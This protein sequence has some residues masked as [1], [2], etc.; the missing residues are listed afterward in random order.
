M[1]NTDFTLSC[2]STVDL[3]Y[4]HME[5]RNI[6]VL[7]YTYTVDDTLYVD[8]MG[9]DAAAQDRFY[10]MLAEGKLP[11]TSQLNVG[12]YEEFFEK[13]L[14]EG[15]DVLHIA[16]GSGMSNSVNNAVL[17][18][19]MLQEKYPERKLLVVDSLCSSSGYGMLV[20]SA[21]DLRDG[22][23]DIDEVYDWLMKRRNRVHHQFFS[24]NMTQFRRSGR[25]SGATAAIATVLNICPIMRLD[26]HGA[27]KAYDKVR[28]KHKGIETTVETMLAN[29]ENGA[30]YDGPCYL[31]HSRCPELAQQMMEAV[32]AA[33]PALQ[34]KIRICEIGTIIASHSGPGT[35]AVFFYGDERP[36]MD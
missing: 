13:L 35:V 33:F 27:I 30:A 21:A 17:A 16:L 2:C 12:T 23:A 22:G 18:A 19:Q 28:G 29:A 34:G 9:R 10:E 11:K 3:P 5:E 32:E 36:E 24:T 8:D 31:C 15:K 20:E 7:F 1:M 6:P 14:A 4:S 26:A 25:V